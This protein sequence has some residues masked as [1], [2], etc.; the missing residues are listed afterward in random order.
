MSARV[1]G[2]TSDAGRVALDLMTT[3]AS[4]GA[5]D[6]NDVVV[7]MTGVSQHHARI[8]KEADEYWLEDTGSSDGTWLNG[9]RITRARLDH[10]DVLT[11]GNVDFV[12]LSRATP[13]LT[14]PDISDPT[15]TTYGA[16]L[17]TRMPR[18]ER[19]VPTAD[20]TV[21]GPLPTLRPNLNAA[22]A[23][24]R[25]GSVRLLGS[26]GEFVV[27]PGTATIGRSPDATIRIDRHEI[28]RLHA[29][30][31]VRDAAIVVEDMGSANGT[32]VNGA[33]VKGRQTLA[34]GDRL[35]LA[36]VEFVIDVG[37]TNR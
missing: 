13:A 24:P 15:R 31:T 28:S 10:L 5:A 2:W 35:A 16:P 6:S 14:S 19:P 18:L 20:R 21:I 3:P 33:I 37:Q 1:V 36:D 4:L 23:H 32:K 27:P 25:A 12:F 22:P 30:I 17:P 34:H 26:A 8:V 7:R 29:A 11:L 9:E